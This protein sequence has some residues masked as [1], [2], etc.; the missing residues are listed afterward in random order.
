MNETTKEMSSE[1]TLESALVFVFA[2]SMAARHRPGVDVE[3]DTFA[4]WDKCLTI[5]RDHIESLPT[6]APSSASVLAAVESGRLVPRVA[7]PTERQS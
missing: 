1:I 5:V 3:A 4:V 7:S 2:T 6:S